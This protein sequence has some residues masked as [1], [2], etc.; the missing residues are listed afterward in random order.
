MVDD[1]SGNGTG[2]VGDGPSIE[3][4]S[5]S[6]AFVVV[7]SD[8]TDL[9]DAVG[10]RNQTTRGLYVG[11]DGNVTCELINHAI[12][13]SVLISAIPAGSILPIQVRKVLSTGTTATLIVAL[14]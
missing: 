12:G 9:A 7:P 1:L 10:V 2:G 13:E 5:A 4:M 14:I 3:Q 6:D 11:G 8:T